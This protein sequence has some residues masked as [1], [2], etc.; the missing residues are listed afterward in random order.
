[1]NRTERCCQRERTKVFALVIVELHGF[2]LA[3]DQGRGGEVWGRLSNESCVV[4]RLMRIERLGGD[5]FW[6]LE[7]GEGGEPEGEG[8]GEG[9]VWISQT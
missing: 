8:E 9:A 6:K 4:K 2:E 5:V 3:V 7:M 1:M